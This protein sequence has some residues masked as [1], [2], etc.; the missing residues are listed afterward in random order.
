MIE[1]SSTWVDAILVGALSRGVN[2]TTFVLINLSLLGAIGLLASLLGRVDA[3]LSLHLGVLLACAVGLLGAVNYVVGQTGLVSTDAQR[4]ELFDKRGTLGAA[5][6]ADSSASSSD[7][8]LELRVAVG[9]SGGVD[10]AVAALLLARAG[11]EVVGV[12]MRNW[13]EG[14]ETGNHNCSV[15]RDARDASAVCRALGVPLHEADFVS[16]YWNEASLGGP[17]L[18]AGRGGE[19]RGAGVFQDFVAQ[20]ARGLTPNPDLACNRHIKFDALLDFADGLGAHAVATGH[21]ARLRWPGG[22]PGGG[23]ASGAGAGGAALP[24]LLRGADPRKDQTYFLASVEREAFARALFPVG[25]LAKPA[26]RALAAEAGLPPAA[27]RSSAGIC[28]IGRRDFGDFLSQYAA[29]VPGRLIDVDTG[30]DLGPCANLL[31]LTHGQRPGLGGMPA[32]T[33]VVGKDVVARVAYVA[34]APDHPG[35][36]CAAALLRAPHWLSPEHAE[37][38]AQQGWLRCEYKA[39][40]GQPTRECVVTLAAAPPAPAAAG[41]AA[42]AVGG[43]RL[44][45]A[46]LCAGFVS[47]AYCRLQPEDG[48]VLPGYLVA[49]F[50]EPAPAITPQQA[51]VLYDGELCLGSAAIAQPGRSLHEAALGKGGGASA[52]PAAAAADAP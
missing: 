31:A 21:Y 12:F 50:P 51:F 17:C 33:Y 39:R 16:R 1:D 15:E 35:L 25:G 5:S 52:G 22:A 2:K 11:H 44:D 7:R 20:C 32:R 10:S 18:G 28:F 27:R 13:D 48:A 36:H 14:E 49:H 43:A 9:V 34:R 45:P 3:E 26:V 37:R 19:R 8:R 46:A 38:L 47:S 29:P 4:R 23:G 24:Q 30:A 41:A 42:A 40:H 6:P